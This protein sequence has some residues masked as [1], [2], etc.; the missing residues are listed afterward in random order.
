MD[1]NVEISK[2]PPHRPEK[3]IDWK[4]VDQLLLAGCTGTEIAANFDIHADT[5]YNRIQEKYGM[6]FTAFSAERRQKGESILRA[7]QY[8][9]ALEKDNTMLI[10]LGK[11]RLNQK[12]PSA[13]PAGFDFD[14]EKLLALASFFQ[15]MANSA[16]KVIEKAPE[17]NNNRSE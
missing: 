13:A 16:S 6:T 8:E 10:W 7:K 2:N 15:G 11:Q 14:K 4:I 9:K 3:P 5:L 1:K 12:E 17:P